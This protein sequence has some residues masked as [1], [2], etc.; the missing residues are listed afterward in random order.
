MHSAVFSIRIWHGLVHSPGS[1]V[2][3]KTCFSYL[4]VRA[5]RDGSGIQQL[6]QQSG[7]SSTCSS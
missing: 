5:A 1:V 7:T 3:Q 6:Y 2:Q 4:L